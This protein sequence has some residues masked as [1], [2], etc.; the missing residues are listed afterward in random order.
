VYQRNRGDIWA[1]VVIADRVPIALAIAAIFFGFR[2]NTWLRIVLAL[3][4][5]AVPLVATM[6]HR[7]GLAVALDYV[8]RRRWPDPT[9]PLPPPQP[10][11][12]GANG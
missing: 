4:V 11:S 12:P 7:V 2:S 1:F 5:V 8:T 3:A 10:G 6:P 9:D